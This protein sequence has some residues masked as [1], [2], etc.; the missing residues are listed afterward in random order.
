MSRGTVWLVFANGDR[1]FIQDVS[2]EDIVERNGVALLEL[3]DRIP[4]RGVYD[5]R[6]PWAEEI[7][8]G[9]YVLAN[10][11]SWKKEASP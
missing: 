8:R 1:T 3:W 5:G 10:I 9:T 11:R 6:A 2:H 4:F 7:S